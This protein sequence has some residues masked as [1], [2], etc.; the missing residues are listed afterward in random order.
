[1]LAAEITERA[2][3]PAQPVTIMLMTVVL[4]LLDTG[5]IQSVPVL[6]TVRGVEMQRYVWI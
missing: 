4:L 3:M 1:M 6:F 5:V 2:A